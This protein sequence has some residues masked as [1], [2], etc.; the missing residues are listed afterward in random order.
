MNKTVIV[1]GIIFFLIG[2]SVVSSTA[3]NAIESNPSDIYYK[4]NSPT[5]L[6]FENFSG[7]F[8]PDGW[9]T[10]WWTQCNYSCVGTEPPCACLKLGDYNQAHITSKAVDASNYE[11]VIL[12]FL[13]GAWGHH[14]SVYFMV[15]VNETSPWKVYTF[16]DN[17]IEDD[18][19]PIIYEIKINLGP[20]GYANAFQ[21]NWTIT[22][23]FYSFQDACLDEVIIYNPPSNNPR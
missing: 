4:M 19:L 23:D 8:P 13:F 21:V 10:D 7:T 5:V 6:L 3:Y 18:L 17:P 22:D 9:S 11:K 2:A 15:R 12:R 16:W 14:Y 20:G 1:I